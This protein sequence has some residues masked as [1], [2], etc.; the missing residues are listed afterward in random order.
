MICFSCLKLF[1]D[2]ISLSLP[3]LFSTCKLNKVD[4]VTNMSTYFGL[5]PSSF[6]LDTLYSL[7]YTSPHSQIVTDFI[8]NQILKK[9]GTGKN[10]A[11]ECCVR[12]TVLQYTLYNL[13]V[14]YFSLFSNPP[15]WNCLNLLKRVLI[16]IFT[17]IMC[18]LLNFFI[19]C[20]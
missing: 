14:F 10:H 7:I 19:R 13:A 1:Q 18:F 3:W 17:P 20:M 11:E 5:N 16:L 15:V 8:T 6:L 2:L 12:K 4:E 9:I